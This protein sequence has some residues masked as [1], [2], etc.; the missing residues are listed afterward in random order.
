MSTSGQG[1]KKRTWQIFKPTGAQRLAEACDL[2][3]IP[4]V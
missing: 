4:P 2:L 1:S 3:G